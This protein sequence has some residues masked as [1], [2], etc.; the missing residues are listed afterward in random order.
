MTI[1]LHAKLIHMF[2]GIKENMWVLVEEVA[3]TKLSN[4]RKVIGE[5]KEAMDS[6]VVVALIEELIDGLVSKEPNSKINIINHILEN[7]ILVGDELLYTSQDYV[8]HVYKK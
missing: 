2:S 5:Y 8:I 3:N 4:R 6:T 1:Q 7:S